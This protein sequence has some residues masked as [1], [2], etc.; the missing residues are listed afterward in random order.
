LVVLVNVPSSIGCNG[1]VLV[2][3]FKGGK[4]YVALL[5]SGLIKVLPLSR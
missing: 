1:S 3:D 2:D 4:V 5:E